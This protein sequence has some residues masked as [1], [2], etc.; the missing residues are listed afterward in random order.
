MDR[1]LEEVRAAATTEVEEKV[2]GV[3]ECVEAVLAVSTRVRSARL[4]CLKKE[5][6]AARLFGSARS[7]LLNTVAHAASRHAS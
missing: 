1:A 3:D 5:S 6:R 2:L 4:F 7:S